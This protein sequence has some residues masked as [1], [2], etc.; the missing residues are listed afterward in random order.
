MIG[1]VLIVMLLANSPV[2]GQGAANVVSGRI[3]VPGGGLVGSIPVMLT[4]LSP[5][6]RIS[7]R[8]TTNDAGSFRFDNVR[9]GEYTVFA[10]AVLATLLPG[11]NNSPQ[12][13]VLSPPALLPT[14]S[15]GTFFPGT[16]DISTA[17]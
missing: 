3:Q 4:T 15:V 8:T 9:P 13:I 6:N 2:L 7:I 14:R 16:S 1:R 5:S 17:T 10:G 11:T 12:A